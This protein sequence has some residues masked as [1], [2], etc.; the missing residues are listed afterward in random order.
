M[1]LVY[2]AAGYLVLSA[3]VTLFLG[4]FMKVGS[5]E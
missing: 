5:G 3:V 1:T 4:A 2:I